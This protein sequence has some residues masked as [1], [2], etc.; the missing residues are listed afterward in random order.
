LAIA[1][2]VESEELMSKS[3]SEEFESLAERTDAI[4]KDAEAEY[5]LK[6]SVGYGIRAL[7]FAIHAIVTAGLVVYVVVIRGLV[8]M[9][10]PTAGRIWNGEHRLSALY[11]LERLCDFLIHLSV[12]IVSIASNPNVLSNFEDISA[13]LKIRALFHLAAVAGVIESVVKGLFVKFTVASASLAFF[14]NLVHLV[15]AYMMELLILQV[16]LGPGIFDNIVCM[17]PVL[18]WGILLLTKCIS[19]LIVMLNAKSTKHTQDR[20]S[21]NEGECNILCA[22]DGRSNELFA[23]ADVTLNYGSVESLPLLSTSDDNDSISKEI[24]CSSST[25]TLTIVPVSCLE[26]CRRTLLGFFGGLRLQSD[27]LLLS[28]MLALLRHCWPLLEVLHPV[29]E[30]FLATFTA[31]ASLPIMVGATVV[32]LVM[33][34]FLFVH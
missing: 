11:V 20:R 13:P 32:L 31:W 17:N 22:N 4:S 2:Q 14:S 15:P 33:V 8:T 25:R 21:I 26:R 24:K 12:A 1:A 19:S 6:Q 30:T 9:V 34:H 28:L 23:P 27:L 5:L 10:V 18:I 16:L 3:T 29:A 7:G